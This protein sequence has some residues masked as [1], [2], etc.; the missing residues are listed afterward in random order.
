M[1]FKRNKRRQEVEDKADEA[2]DKLDEAIASTKK[3]NAILAQN[4]LTIKFKRS[5]GR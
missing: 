5:L 2:M 1:M 4:N 3:V